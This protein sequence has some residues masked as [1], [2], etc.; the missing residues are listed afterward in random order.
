MTVTRRNAIKLM[1]AGWGLLGTA[2]LGLAGPK[3]ALAATPECNDEP[4]ERMI[5]GPYFTPNSP[6]RRVLREAATIGAPLTITGRVLDT[7]C[8]PIAH[9]LLDVW[10]ADG[11]GVYDNAGYRLRGHQYTDESGSFR[12]ETVKPGF[13]GPRFAR[14]TPHI[15]VKVKGERTP[16]LTTQ[17]YFPDEA[18]NAG[19]DLFRESLLMDVSTAANGSLAARFDFVLTLES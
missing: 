12:I 7:D 4:T 19:D 18:L 15:H 8:R 5:E 14:R 11:D 10:S 2:A 9:A 3:P 13:Y 6:E 17:L 1:G 16:L